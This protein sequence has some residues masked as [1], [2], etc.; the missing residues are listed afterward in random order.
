MASIA[1]FHF[2]AKAVPMN[3]APSLNVYSNIQGTE[4]CGFNIR[5]KLRQGA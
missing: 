3:G 2:S 4:N 1:G 5:I